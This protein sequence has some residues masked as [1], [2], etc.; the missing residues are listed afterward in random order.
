MRPGA[1]VTA[2]GAQ[3]LTVRGRGDVN[4]VRDVSASVPNPGSPRRVTSE[5]LWATAQAGSRSVGWGASVGEAGVRPVEH[6]AVEAGVR[7]LV[8]RRACRRKR[9]SRD[10]MQKLRSTDAALPNACRLPRRDGLGSDRTGA[11]RLAGRL[12]PRTR[13]LDECRD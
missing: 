7:P 13:R 6:S 12:L 3:V 5:C 8:Q 10:K 1:R 11:R 9:G 2:S 4:A